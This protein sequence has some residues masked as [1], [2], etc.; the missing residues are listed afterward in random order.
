MQSLH[1]IEGFGLCCCVPV[2]SPSSQSESPDGMWKP[3]LAWK[4]SSSV[5]RET[6]NGTRWGQV[7]PGGARHSQRHGLTRGRIHGLG[8]VTLCNYPAAQN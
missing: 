1:H 4:L 5:S 8:R 3:Q 6:K 7:G 2:A